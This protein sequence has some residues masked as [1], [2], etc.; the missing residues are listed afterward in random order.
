M[1]LASASVALALRAVGDEAERPAMHVVEAGIAALGEGAQQVQR[2][3]RLAVGHALARRIGH[4]R[5]SASN[6]MPLMMSPR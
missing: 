2:R 5:T 4:A 6:S 1:R 3:G